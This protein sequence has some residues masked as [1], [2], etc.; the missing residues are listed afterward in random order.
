MMSLSNI[1]YRTK[2][3]FRFPFYTHPQS[4]RVTLDLFLENRGDAHGVEVVIPI[5]Q[6]SGAQHVEEES[7]SK[8]VE[9]FHDSRFGNRVAIWK[10]ALPAGGR[11][12]LSASFLV[13][14]SPTARSIARTHEERES[15]LHNRFFESKDAKEIALSIVPNE[16]DALRI[17][18][19]FNEYVVSHFQYGNPIRGLYPA[20]PA[21]EKRVVDC[22]GFDAVLCSLCINR[23]IPARI[24][25]G[26]W[27]GHQGQ[28]MM[29]AWCEFMDSTGEWIPA[30]PSIEYLVQSGRDRTKSGRF[31]Y[32]GSDRI[33]FSVGCDI[34]LSNGSSVDI[35]QHPFFLDPSA[36]LVLTSSYAAQRL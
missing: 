34:L 25:S 16:K 15:F 2:E 4:Y 28:E 22:G 24:V 33:V 35:L 12:A 10:E 6:R 1:L 32:I 18:R 13:T 36:A 30:D 21:F 29:H 3:S 31:S 14:V 19:V 11:G 23:G 8:T 20:Q 9:F 5:P 17:A 7:F 27:A 26:F